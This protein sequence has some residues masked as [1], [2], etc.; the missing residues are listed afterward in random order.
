MQ[1]AVER[2]PTLFLILV[3]AFLFVLMASNPQTRQG[4]EQQTLLIRSVIRVVAPILKGVD[5][6]YSSVTNVYYGYLDMRRAVSENAQLRRKI[7]DLTAENVSLR[8]ENSE[9]ARVR[10]LLGYTET[11]DVPATL[12]RVVMI[13][14]AGSFKSLVLDRG[15]SSGIEINDPVIS[16]DGLVG[17][18]V[19]TTA[20]VSKVQLLLDPDASAGV[21]FERTRRQGVARGK[22]SSN[23]A[24]AFVPV[25]AD[26]V[27]G[28]RVF[29]AGID[30]I[31]PPGIPV[32]R[33]TRVEKGKDLFTAVTCPPSADFTSLEELIVLRIKKLDPAVIEFKP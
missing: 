17:R 9:L 19:L 8:G 20:N 26:V 33:V 29:T 12:A 13:D 28:D 32:G 21:M 31:Y 5:T 2:R 4:G 25:T 16:S 24:I 3:L 7:A 22:G 1:A 23:L 18:V 6:A 10:A 30:G 15:S 27:V 11:T 14:S